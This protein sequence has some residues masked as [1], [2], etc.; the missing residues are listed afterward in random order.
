MEKEVEIKMSTKIIYDYLIYNTY[1]S[2]QGII[3]VF[4]GLLMIIGFLCDMG[5]IYLI[6][7]IV[8]ILYLPWNLYLKAGLQM[9]R[10]ETFKKPLKFIF[11]DEGISVAQDGMQEMQKWEDMHKAVSTMNSIIVYTSKYNAT[12]LPK[13]QLGADKLNIIEIIST[14]MDPKKVKIRLI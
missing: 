12:I 5:I 2:L 4:I 9:Q 11:T 8:I 13:K 1:T 10:N 14:H 7:G 3:G 6:L